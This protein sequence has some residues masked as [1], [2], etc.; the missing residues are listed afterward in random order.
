MRVTV[1]NCFAGGDTL[2][3]SAIFF[4]LTKTGMFGLPFGE[5]RICRSCFAEITPDRQGYTD[6]MHL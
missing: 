1:E 4:T 6:I 3:I 2:H 5:N